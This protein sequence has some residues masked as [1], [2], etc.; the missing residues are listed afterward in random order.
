MTWI[1]V[2]CTDVHLHQ[3]ICV[4]GTK[5]VNFHILPLGTVLEPS[6]DADPAPT[7]R[8]LCIATTP[9]PCSASLWSSLLSVPS[10]TCIERQSLCICPDSSLC[11][12]TWIFFSHWHGWDD[13]Q[14]CCQQDLKICFA[15]KKATWGIEFCG[16]AWSGIYH[17][18]RKLNS[19][20]GSV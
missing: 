18:C 8:G 3:Y 4:W 15:S 2:I 16:I 9:A 19:G 20:G 12:Q 1:T 10:G 11:A 17:L 13:T 14:C 6:P 5:K 7:P